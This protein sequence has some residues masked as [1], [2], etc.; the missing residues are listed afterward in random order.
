MK[1]NACPLHQ[2]QQIRKPGGGE[3]Q[4]LP[5]WLS[6]KELTCQCRRHRFDLWSRKVPHATEH[7]SWFTTT[8]EPTCSNYWSPHTPEPMVCSKKSHCMRSPH[9]ATREKPQQQ[10]RPSTA[11]NK[12][13]K[14]FLRKHGWGRSTF[15]KICAK[16]Y[17]EVGWRIFKKDL[18]QWRN[19][20]QSWTVLQNC[21]SPLR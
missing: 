11:K 13:K 1:I 17:A 20:S 10:W 5:W 12:F 21:Q 9:T 15:S 18:Y 14:N 8:A 16:I 3:Q 2:Q 7:L 6:G 4:V 19:G